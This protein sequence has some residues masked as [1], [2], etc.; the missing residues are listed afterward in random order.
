[1]DTPLANYIRY[2]QAAQVTSKWKKDLTED[3]VDT[4]RYI[5][6]FH[7]VASFFQCVHVICGIYVTLISVCVYTYNYI[8]M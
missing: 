7:G 5:C 6:L 1:M 8:G 4:P 2:S 3:N